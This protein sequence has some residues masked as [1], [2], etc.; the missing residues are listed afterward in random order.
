M[1]QATGALEHASV[2]Q[3]C[4]VL[5]LPVMGANSVSLGGADQ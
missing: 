5:R 4:K 3:Y 2:K 1:K